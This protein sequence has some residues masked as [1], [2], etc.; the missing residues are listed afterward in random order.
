MKL[1]GP[2]A[3]DIEYRTIGLDD[4]IER[5]CSAKGRAE[6][7][8]GEVSRFIGT[9]RDIGKLKRAEAQQQMLTRELEHR[10]KNTMAMVG[11][12]ASQTFRTAA[13]KEDARTIFDARLAALN[14]A[15]DILTQSSWTSASMP[16]VI[17]GALA[18]HRTG[19]KRI[20]VSGPEVELTAKQALSL[21]LALHELATNATKYGALSVPDG[22][23]TIDWACHTGS[24]G[25]ALG[26]VWRESGGPVVAP[27]TR[28]GFGSR[29]IEGTLSADFG[30]SVK[31]EFLP[32]GLTC[33]FETRLSD[34]ASVPDER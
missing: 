12:I 24:D 33:R 18:P 9:I 13:T 10:M 20:R 16:T 30:S 31:I 27:P 3:Y 28:R 19:E 17:A 14:Q 22:T 2:Q 34:L 8:N 15:H 4:G 11:A 32:E 29:L 25:P 7:E 23:I 1:D 5:W 6:F 26:F 21:A